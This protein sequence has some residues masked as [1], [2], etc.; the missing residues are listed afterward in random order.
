MLNNKYLI[1]N[2][3]FNASALG[4]NAERMFHTVESVNRIVE[5]MFHDA[6]YRFRQQAA[7]NPCRK[8]ALRQL[9]RSFKT[10]LNFLS[11]PK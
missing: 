10:C 7:T 11:R 6:V 2:I 8:F 9:F 3:L 1:I 5:C 4:G